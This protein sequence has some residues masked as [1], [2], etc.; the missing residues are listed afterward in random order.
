M[1]YLIDDKKNRQIDFGWNEGR[2]IAFEDIIMPIYSNKEIIENNYSE[3]M[4]LPGNIVLFHESFFDALNNN[5]EKTALEIRSRLT[6]ISQEIRDFKV[7]YFS[8]SKSSRRL[9]GNVAFMPVAALYQ[10]LSVFAEKVKVGDNNLNY[11]LFGENYKIEEDLLNKLINANNEIDSGL[12]NNK[13]QSKN[14][15]AQTMQYGIEKIFENARYETFYLDETYNNEVTDEYLT[16]IINEWFS[17]EEYDNVFIPICFGPT[18]SDYNGLRFALHLRCSETTNRL[19]NIF[20]YG[21]VDYSFLVENEYFDILKTKNINL[22]DYK[23]IAFQKAI[24]SSLTSYKSI[25]LASEIRKIKLD[26]PKNYEDSHSIANEWAI[27]LWSSAINT[28]DSDIDKIIGNVNNQ[29]YFKYLKTI[30]PV[31][32]IPNIKEEQIKIKY[33]GEP[34][35]LYID[36]EA[37][38]GWYEVFCTILHDT[39]NLEFQHIDGELQNKTREEIVK[40][41]IEKI[42]NDDID[43]VL[44]DFRLHPDDFNTKNI[45]DITGLKLLREIKKTNPGVRVVI[46]S[47]TNKIWNLIEL[48]NAGADAFIIKESPDSSLSSSFTKETIERFSQVLQEQLKYQFQKELFRDCKAIKGILINQYV[49][50]NEAYNIFIKTL[51]RQ[52]DIIQSSISLINLSKSVTIDIVF[53][54]C[55]NFLELFKGYYLTFNKDYRYYLGFEEELLISYAVNNS[56]NEVTSNG[57][58]VAKNKFDSPSWFVTLAGLFIHYFEVSKPPFSEVVKLKRI[59]DKRNSYIHSDKKYFDI[60]E[61]RLIFDAL[62]QACA[63]IK[64]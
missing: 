23:K 17:T 50:E 36:D 46:F 54:A 60:N 3:K 10:H 38:K 11:L 25:E 57:E 58:F 48:Q 42:E 30:N 55:Y 39:N 16:K 22:I 32:N 24:E 34:K 49:D 61:L 37:E 31:N 64:E 44:L 1:I 29:L 12:K 33:S 40:L 2:F 13:P 43:L 15:I 9:D 62:K 28:S 20:L 21:F 56:T 45:Q 35:I 4:F 41:S 5:H 27:Y 26:P 7:V 51:V 14:F 59:A 63:S 47:A 18:L 8:G 19:N 6:K 53:L 52:I